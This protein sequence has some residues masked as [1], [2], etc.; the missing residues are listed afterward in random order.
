[1]TRLLLFFHFLGGSI[2]AGLVNLSQTPMMTAPALLAHASAAG[3]SSAIHGITMLPS[4]SAL[5]HGSMV[6]PCA[7]RS[8]G[9]RA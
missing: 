1:M 6:L 5:L 9:L 2:A 8:A 4:T 3:R 7:A